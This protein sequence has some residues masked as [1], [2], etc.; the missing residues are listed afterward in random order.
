MRKPP[1]PLSNQSEKQNIK[2]TGVL[3]KGAGFFVSR[4]AAFLRKETEDLK[5]EEARK[6]AASSSSVFC[7][8]VFCLFE[9]SSSSPFTRPQILRRITQ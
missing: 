2:Q 4:E 6:E 3:T 7:L 8:E 5:T 9:T 1:A